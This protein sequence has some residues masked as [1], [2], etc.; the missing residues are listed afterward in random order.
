MPHS[1]FQ[2]K[3]AP[4]LHSWY[5]ANGRDLPFR[6][7]KNPYFI[8]LSEIILQQTQIAQG[9]PYYYKFVEKYPTITLLANAPEADVLKLWEGLG[10]YSRARNLHFTAKYICEV[11]NGIFPT[12]YDDI[13]KLKGIGPYTAAAIAGIA[14]N[15]P[16]A[17]VDG[18]VLR[19]MSRYF[20]IN[21]PIDDSKTIKIIQAVADLHLNTADVSTYN[22]S[23]I[24]FGA[25]QCTA[26]KPACTTCVLA[27]TCG[28]YNYGLVEKLPFKT[29]KIKKINRFLAYIAITDGTSI[30]I[31]VRQAGDIWQGL[32]EFVIFEFEEKAFTEAGIFEALETVY[33]E[34]NN[35]I[36][37]E[38]AM[39]HL[40]THQTLM[41]K[42]FILKVEK[43]EKNFLTE[44]QIVRIEKL[45]KFAFPK[46][47]HS[48]VAEIETLFLK[49][50]I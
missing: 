22:Q 7:T 16:K 23:L 27:A 11:Y 20:G 24:E 12:A 17:A 10:Y 45:K 48:L 25:L 15:Y 41:A 13:L 14:F 8:W 50:H 4:I 18:N 35:V 32:N 3:L 19:F 38:N 37:Y 28:A 40:L 6:K 31:K 26:A 21:A 29:K 43:I 9:L 1:E 49:N 33:P 2:P 34:H 42:L 47:L 39:K 5:T 36:I 46:I 30:A 44:Y